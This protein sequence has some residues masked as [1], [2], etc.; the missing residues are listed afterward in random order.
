MRGEGEPGN[1]ARIHLPKGS[2]KGDRRASSGSPAEHDSFLTAAQESLPS[3]RTSQSNTRLAATKC[4]LMR[5]VLILHY[6]N[7]VAIG[8]FAG[9]GKRGGNCKTQDEFEHTR[10][11]F[12]SCWGSG[13]TDR[14]ISAEGADSQK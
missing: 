7:M 1:E 13:P 4:L 10:H 14:L 11:C 3:P 9:A 2:P 8:E 5:K 6:N 12:C